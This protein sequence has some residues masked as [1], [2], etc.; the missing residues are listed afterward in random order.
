MEV[1]ASTATRGRLSREALLD[2]A[3][4]LAD[5][6]GLQALTFRRLAATMGATPMA[7][8]WHVADKE[9]LLAALGERL[10]ADVELPAPRPR[11]TW[12]AEL[13]DAL[14]ALL[15]A[16]ER[17]PRVAPLALTTVL[18]SE[19]GLTVAERVLAL[20]SQAGFDDE[21]AAQ[22][23]VFVLSSLVMLVTEQ[24][25]AEVRSTDLDDA[26]RASKRAALAALPA[27]RFP[28]VVRMADVLSSCP[29]TRAY[30]ERG[31]D[32]LVRGLRDTAADL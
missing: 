25:G 21:T 17:H 4:A 13:H 23:G 9:A 11:R 19:A 26:E 10:F 1:V 5:S 28:S 18:I 15:T 29:D 22:H 27:A 16:L 7:L 31:L 6:E 14:A 2:A 3:L 30:Y 20:I 24:P 8:Y 12:H 32:M